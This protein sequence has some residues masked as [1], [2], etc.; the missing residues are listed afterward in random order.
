[1]ASTWSQGDWNLGSWNDVATG[2]SV[3]GIQISSLT[4]DVTTSLGNGS[5]FAIIGQSIG[6]DVNL[7]N[8]WSREEWSTGAWNQPIGSIIAGSGTIF[9]EDGQSVTSSVNNVSVTGS[10]PINISGEELTTSLGDE[11][12]IAEATVQA[13]GE[14]LTTTVNTF[15]VSAGGAITINTPT[16][17]ANVELNNDGI[18]VGTAT[19]LDITG[20]ELTTFLGNVIANSENFITITTAGQSNTTVNTISLSTVNIIDITGNSLT[21]SSGNVIANSENFLSITGNQANVTATNLKF[22][23]PITGNIVETWVNIH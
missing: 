16:L 21:T 17:E 7:G 14:E 5:V 3:T 11:T 1:M 4:G 10:A 23:D 6:I 19:F 2:A 15:A 9:I 18:V 13:T 8:G 22:W 20:Q 12:V